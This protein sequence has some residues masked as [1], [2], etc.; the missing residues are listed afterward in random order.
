MTAE[1]KQAE[2]V[3]DREIRAIRVFDAPRELVWDMFT[4]LEHLSQWWGPTG[5]TT[6]TKSMDI[7]TGGVWRFTMHGPDGR[8]YENKIT[9][10]EVTPP[11]KIVFKHGGADTEPV[12]HETHITLEELGPKKTKLTFLMKFVSPKA[13]DFVMKEYNAAQGL[14]ETLGRL[15]EKLATGPT[16]TGENVKPF[17]LSRTFD[18]PLSLV[19]K[20]WTERD[21]LT[22]WFGPQGW[23]M[24]HASLDLRPGG[25]FL[26]SLAMPDGKTIWGKFVYRE[27]VP[28]ERIVWVNSFSDENAGITRH[29]FGPD[30]PIQ[31]FS[32]ATFKEENGKTTVTIY[33]RP[34]NP[35]DAERKTFDAGHDSMTQGWGG[36]FQ[37]LAG[38]LPTAKS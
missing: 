32:Q 18:A 30:W 33:W 23:K 9:Y 2:L 8:D 31:L 27:I 29:P 19:W 38:Y 6:T 17:I 11:S 7:R 16:D 34:I 14:T 21:R 13:R 25:T 22:Q 4:K 3:G 15:E 26:Y 28:Q 10:L 35:T 20:A 36:T 1:S 24:T 5:F 37:Q 12:N